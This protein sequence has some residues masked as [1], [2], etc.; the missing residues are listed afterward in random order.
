MVVAFRP[1]RRRDLAL[2]RRETWHA[3]CSTT[4]ERIVAM[5]SVSQIRRTRRRHQRVEILAPIE[6]RLLNLEISGQ[7]RD[8][9]E[10]GF[11][12]GSDEPVLLEVPHLVLFTFADGWSTVLMACA[13]HSSPGDDCAHVTGFEFEGTGD[14]M[15]R[16]TITELLGRVTVLAAP[17]AD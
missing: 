15:T 5:S 6:A 14:P 11:G 17:S 3:G 8:V 13:R 16:R 9:S 1:N 12:L 4:G 7:V 2:G 10:G